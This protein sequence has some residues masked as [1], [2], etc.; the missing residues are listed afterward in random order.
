MNKSQLPPKEEKKRIRLFKQGM[1]VEKLAKECGI[2]PKSMQLWLQSRGILE[3][4]TSRKG[5]GVPMESVLTPGQC[6][7]MEYFLNSLCRADSLAKAK[8]LKTIDVS[9]FMSEWRKSIGADIKE[10]MS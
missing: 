1:P 6:L 4:P 2:L 3:P 9:S 8:G 10:A 5:A 7:V